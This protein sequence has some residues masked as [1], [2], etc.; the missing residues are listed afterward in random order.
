MVDKI[1]NA[2]SSLRT[3][4]L[5]AIVMALVAGTAAIVPQ[6]WAA[7]EFARVENATRMQTLAA[8]GL[9]DIFDSAWIRA[10][11]ALLVMNV[12]AG[13]DPQ[14]FAHVLVAR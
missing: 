1:W 9:T 13:R 4:A 2:M 7:L 8:W 10:V 11:A 6:G 12:V 3:T 5:L 14:L